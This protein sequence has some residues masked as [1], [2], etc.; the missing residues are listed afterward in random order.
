MIDEGNR[1]ALRIEI[2]S[3]ITAAR[4]VRIIDALIEVYGAPRAIRLD[5]GAKLTS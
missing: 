4:V 3:S 2:D 5:N 1:E